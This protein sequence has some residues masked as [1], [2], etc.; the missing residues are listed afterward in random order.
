LA[1]AD[2][3]LHLVVAGGGE[4]L[5]GFRE[6]AVA[7]GVADRVHFLGRVPHAELP[8]VLRACDAIL[9][10]T[11]PPESFGI[12]LIEGMACGLPA[13]VTEYPGVRAVVDEGENGL[14][15]PRGDP[16]A[17]AAALASLVEMGVGARR[18]M[19]AAGREKCE[20]SWSWPSLAD[21]MDEVYAE[22]IAARREK[23]T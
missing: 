17:V 19:G 5:E 10:T 11:D 15:V 2:T 18:A 13:V 7:A 1:R 21:R 8:D 22:A 9:L 20:R 6:R 12:V 23:L 14:V 4:L 16:T 3:R